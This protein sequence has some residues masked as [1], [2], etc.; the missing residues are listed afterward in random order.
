MSFFSKIRG[1]F[2]GKS[3]E[4]RLRTPTLVVLHP[5]VAYVSIKTKKPTL[6]RK[7]R[8]EKLPAG[9]FRIGR[10]ELGEE[11]HLRLHD[12]P[13][14]K[15]IAE[16]HFEF[17]VDAEGKCWVKDLAID[18]QMKVNGAFRDTA[19][20]RHGDV[21]TS[22][23]EKAAPPKVAIVFDEFGD[24]SAYFE[25]DPGRVLDHVLA[26]LGEKKEEKK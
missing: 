18:E 20:L 15:E 14:T 25:K 11:I 9:V 21:I 1:F 16:R 22:G 26:K 17:Q 6:V 4:R 19:A 12:N 2:A 7:V 10:G 24:L 5:V 3:A 13:G 23:A 8:V